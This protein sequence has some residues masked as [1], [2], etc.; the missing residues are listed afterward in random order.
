MADMQP[1]LDDEEAGAKQLV[2][3]MEDIKSKYQGVLWDEHGLPYT[4]VAVGLSLAIVVSTCVTLFLTGYWEDFMK[5]AVVGSAT[6][7]ILLAMVL[8]LVT[9]ALRHQR[10]VMLM[11]TEIQCKIIDKQT[12]AITH[13]VK[14]DME[15]TVKD[16]M[17]Y[18]STAV[19]NE[20]VEVKKDVK[21]L[22]EKV[23]KSITE[24]SSK[25]MSHVTG[26]FEKKK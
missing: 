19:T 5:V 2:K 22:P 20:F 1:M 10:Q 4:Q 24:E 3:E 11:V 6:L 9:W 26:W 12:S 15:K 14:K 25:V 16:E 7:M 13:Q 17:K 8:P 18:V 23:Y 21:E